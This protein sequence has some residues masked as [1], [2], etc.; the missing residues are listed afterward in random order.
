ML[1]TGRNLTKHF[2]PRLLF[3]DIT[4]GLSEGERVGLIGANGS[5]KSTLLRIFAGVEHADEGELVARRGLRVGYVP[6]EDSFDSAATCIALVAEQID[7]HLDDHERHIRAELML[8]RAGFADSHATVGTLSG[9][10][11][12][13]LAVVRQLAR[14]PDLLLMD[15]PTN[16]L[17]VEGILWLEK[18]IAGGNFG[19][20]IVSHD[21]RFL[22]NVANRIIELGRAYPAGFLSYDGSYSNFL[23]K[24]EEFLAAQRGREQ[25]L[26]S[27][28]RREI[29]WLRRGA[30]ARTT[31]AKG[32]IE[33][34]NEMMSDLADLRQR[35][36]QA[37]AARIDFTASDRK[38]RKLVELKHV[39][40]SVP[41][42][43]RH[44]SSTA[45]ATR[46]LFHD[47]NL[48]L[49]PGTKLGLL[50]PN[51]SGKSTLIRLLNGE[52]E[53][54][55]GE[56]F[57]AD[58]LR[59]VVFDQHREQLDQTQT[60]RHALSPG[61]DNLVVNGVAMHV[62]GWAKRFLFRTEQLDMP[63]S[64][65]SG[66]EQ[67]RVL[68]ARLMVQPADVLILD[69][70]T[71]D[72]DIATLDVLEESLEQFTG[73]L[74]LVTHDRYLLERVSTEIVALDGKGNAN[75]YVDL[76]QWERAREEAEQAELAAKRAAQPKPVAAEKPKPSSEKKRLTWNEQRELEKMEDAILA[77]E[78]EVES[79]QSQ[80][81]D[82][83]VMANHV[84]LHEAY[85]KLAAAQHEVERLYA[86]WADLESRK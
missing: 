21:R 15:E 42:R 78:T 34:A 25:A 52:L 4:L 33:R 24:R 48:V 86:R 37:G 47:V 56:I 7:A 50:G 43:Q 59:V 30:K 46:V 44:L 13:R 3:S 28:V 38:T 16:H 66:G 1:L 20:L 26:A 32:R 49:S 85:E 58:Q 75:I 10:W 57:R 51:G 64:E 77:A 65:L 17:D 54:D 80:V 70:P 41:D 79:L 76:A 83:K 40:R 69:E 11:K 19:T 81:A 72:L 67:A 2:G 9:G 5:G 39:S 6:Q 22:E 63:V 36:T 18:T 12:K 35:N 71:N 27:G 53:P 84:Q 14:E 74:V 60:L 62:T 61:G 8:D 55:S 82:P 29:E 31:K 73:A 68:I 45:S 23:E